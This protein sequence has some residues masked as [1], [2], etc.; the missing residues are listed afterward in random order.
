MSE[1][2]DIDFSVIEELLG[3]MLP[4]DYKELASFY[5]ALEF[6]GFLVVSLPDPGAET[7]FVAGVQSRLDILEDLVEAGMTEGYVGHPAVNGLLPWA[8]SLSGDG[9]YWRRS[10]GKAEEWPVV[11]GTRNQD[12]WEFPGGALAFLGGLID[13]SI[14]RLGLPTSVPSRHPRIRPFV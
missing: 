10:S 11:V 13:G 9:F 4:R 12:W 8:E 6:D 2:R 1:S 3:V 14:E 7:S 5:P